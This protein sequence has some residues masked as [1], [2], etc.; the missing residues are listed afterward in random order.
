MRKLTK[1]DDS[2]LFEELTWANSLII[3]RQKK[4]ETTHTDDDENEM[5]EKWRKEQT[6]PNK[7]RGIDG[8]SNNK[9]L[10]RKVFTYRFAFEQRTKKEASSSAPKSVGKGNKHTSAHG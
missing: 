8:T 1:M 7:T 4:N 3:Q 2:K 10:E 9:S 5:R 6:E